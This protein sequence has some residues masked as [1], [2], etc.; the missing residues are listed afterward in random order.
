[1]IECFFITISN[2]SS[3]DEPVPVDHHGK[4]F[5]WQER[6]CWSQWFYPPELGYSYLEFSSLNAKKKGMGMSYALDALAGS[7]CSDKRQVLGVKA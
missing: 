2:S 4:G 6:H 7:E 5:R 3:S 1:M